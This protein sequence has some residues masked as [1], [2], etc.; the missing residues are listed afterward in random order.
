ME[1]EIV[2]DGLTLTLVQNAT[3]VYTIYVQGV[4]HDTDIVERVTT[5]TPKDFLE[6]ALPGVLLLNKI[7]GKPLDYLKYQDYD[8][9]SDDRLEYSFEE[10]SV[11]YQDIVPHGFMDWSIDKYLNLKIT[12][13]D[14]CNLY[15]LNPNTVSPDQAANIINKAL[16]EYYSPDE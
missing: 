14:G 15:E 16:E 8:Y 4:T 1:K 2:R 11:L 9:D 3:P 13:Y 6:K 7:L 5:Y 10:L 12:Y